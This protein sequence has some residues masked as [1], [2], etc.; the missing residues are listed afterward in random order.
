MNLFFRCNDKKGDT[1]PTEQKFPNL[2][3]PIR[4]GNVGAKNRIIFEPTTISCS[5]AD[6]S[7]SELDI[8]E[9]TEIARGG[10]SMICKEL[11]GDEITE[12]N[13]LSGFMGGK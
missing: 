5:N 11:T 9:Y 8:A 3:K 6:W 12:E 7:I 13:I 1:M 10:Y 2:F 4:I